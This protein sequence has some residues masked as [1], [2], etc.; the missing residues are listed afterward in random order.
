MML[1]LQYHLAQSTTMPLHTVF[2]FKKEFVYVRHY[3]KKKNE[4]KRNDLRYSPTLS[5]V[6]QIAQ[7]LYPLCKR[8]PNKNM[9]K[10]TQKQNTY[11]F[12]M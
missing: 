7:Q 1:D 3:L 8:G 9:A 11:K 2:V 6:V 4:T 5:I 10:N 12:Y